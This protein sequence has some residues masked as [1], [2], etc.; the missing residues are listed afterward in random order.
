MPKAKS[1][2]DAPEL[3]HNEVATPVAPQVVPQVAE[4]EDKPKSESKS[5]TE[6]MKKLVIVNS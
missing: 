6:L 5:I 2:A 1:K 4:V 3:N